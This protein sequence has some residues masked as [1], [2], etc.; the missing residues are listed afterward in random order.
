MTNTFWDKYYQ[1][2]LD[3]IPWQ[4]TQADWFKELVD[5]KTITGKTAIDLGCGTGNK[6]RYLAEE[7]GFK[8]V[9][10]VDIS[11]KAVEIAKQNKN[12]DCEFIVHDIGDWFFAKDDETFD[13][14]LD[15]AAIHCL[16]LEQRKT[17]AQNIKKHSH[18]GTLFL[19]RSFS[20]NS[21][22]KYFEEEIEGVKARVFY[23][24]KDELIKLFPDFEILEENI[25]RPSTKKN[26]F[27]IEILM[28]KK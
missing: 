11:K 23:L 6:S 28:R 1:K 2:P 24:K 7:G 25:S 8:K 19:I 12:S 9:L 20:T 10:G 3:Q 18:K 4:N 22:D 27:F 17:Y 15:W 16:S 26:I 5:K 21:E 13:F 14:I